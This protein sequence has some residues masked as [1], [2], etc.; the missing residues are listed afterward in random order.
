MKCQERFSSF[1]HKCVKPKATAPWG[2]FLPR[3]RAWH[4][5]PPLSSVFNLLSG[6]RSLS[7]LTFFYRRRLCFCSQFSPPSHL[8]IHSSSSPFSLIF[9]PLA[10]PR[11]SS[12]LF[13]PQKS[14]PAIP[15]TCLYVSIVE[16]EQLQVFV[17]VCMHVL[18]TEQRFLP[19]DHY[20]N[21]TIECTEHNTGCSMAPFL[22]ELS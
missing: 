10:P 18:R 22:T 17:C 5:F 14:K 20:S 15:H 11:S 9:S 7:P 3:E 1:D 12:D 6:T 19:L 13:C 21:C 16:G 2:Q 4:T 8:L